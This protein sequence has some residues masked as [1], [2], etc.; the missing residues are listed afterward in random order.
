MTIIDEVQ[1]HS[2]PPI[3]MN[4]LIPE[5]DWASNEDYFEQLQAL[6]AA[7]HY[8]AGQKLEGLTRFDGSLTSDHCYRVSAS[9]E[10]AC[11]T[12]TPAMVIAAML[13]DVVEDTKTTLDEIEELFGPDVRRLVDAVSR[14][15][16]AD[17]EKEP[18]LVDF[19][20]RIALDRQ[21]LEIKRFDLLDNLATLPLRHDLASRYTIA[22]NILLNSLH[23]E[24]IE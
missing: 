1:M 23:D 17:G 6:K 13:H 16:N 2:N 4:A 9:L 12:A 22:L 19:I 7:T 14:R 8:Y 10:L 20:P 15:V 11:S 3:D 24:Y 21:A 5:F 18:Y